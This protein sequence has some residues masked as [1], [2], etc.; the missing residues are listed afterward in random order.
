MKYKWDEG[1]L[2]LD[3]TVTIRIFK[4]LTKRTSKRKF[5]NAR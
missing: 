3:S 4:N 2:Y 5:T 1:K